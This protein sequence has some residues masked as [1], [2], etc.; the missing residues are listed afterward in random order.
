MKILSINEKIF[1]E[2]LYKEFSSTGLLENV[3]KVGVCEYKDGTTTCVLIANQKKDYP[4]NFNKYNLLNLTGDKG[5]SLGSLGK[6][7]NFDH[8]ILEPTLFWKSRKKGTHI[9]RYIK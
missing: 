3:Y 9:W 4:K 2:V 7:C 8:I 1:L 6:F 5:T